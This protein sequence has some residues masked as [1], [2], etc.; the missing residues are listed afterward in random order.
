MTFHFDLPNELIA[1]QPLPERSASRML[2]LD[3]ATQSFTDDV[4]ANF[5]KYLR[6]GD[7]LVLNNTR[8][9]PARLFGV[10][11][12]HTGKIEI[13]LLR[14]LGEQRWRAL[15]RPGKKLR[16]GQEV[17][18]SENLK[19]TIVEHLEMGERILQLSGCDDV[20][21][22]LN[23]IG[24]MPL[25]PYIDRPDE[26]SDR[27]RYQTVFSKHVGAAAAPTAGLHFTPEILAAAAVPVAEVTL[28]V[29]LGTFQP[30]SEE[31]LRTGKLHR[32]FYE[33]SP[34]SSAILKAAQ[35]RVAIGTTSAR[36]IETTMDAGSGETDIFIR[37]G[38]QFQAVGAL[39]TNFHLPD[40]S[41]IMLVAAFAGHDLTMRAYAHAIATR[42]RF[43]SYGD[44]M[45]IL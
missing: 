28:H 3:R 30:L 40:S 32:E 22:E 21:A 36:T 26:A 14:H 25:P 35:R 13:F 44:C 11:P 18:L 1:R 7:C 33:I 10:R 31:S 24:H 39:L 20:E 37:P 5:P 27:E 42:Y 12:G 23:R 9:I 15:V 17:L 29:G 4:F 41:L 16:V 8:V 6:P 19:A 43:F 45:L 2:V 34:E 38:Y